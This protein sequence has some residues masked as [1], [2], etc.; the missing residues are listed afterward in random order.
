MARAATIR[1]GRAEISPTP[2]GTILRCVDSV[3]TRRAECEKVPCTWKQGG[4][5]HSHTFLAVVTCAFAL[6][7]PPTA[8]STPSSSS[9]RQ[10]PAFAGAEACK[11]CH[12][13]VHE[14]W[15]STK[16]ARALGRLGPADREGTACL[17]CHT[18]GTPEM[19]AA[20]GATPSLPGVQCE[21]CHGPG[22]AHIDAAKAGNPR[23]RI[24]KTPGEDVCTRCHNPDSPHYKSFYYSA[25]VG[26][27]HRRKD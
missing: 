6:L 9:S 27:V 7:W 12:A 15:A 18:T 17:R 10:T 21:A 8:G 1:A 3:A 11:E 23:S 20:E 5:M 16:H 4:T 13:N 22:R 25:L 2:L 24:T 19:I 14:A 26:L